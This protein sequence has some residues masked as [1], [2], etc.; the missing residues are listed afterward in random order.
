MFNFP[1]LS[2]WPKFLKLSTL[3]CCIKCKW[4][5]QAAYNWRSNFVPIFIELPDV[6]RN[7]GLRWCWC[8]TPAAAWRGRLCCST[9]IPSKVCASREKTCLEL[10]KLNS[11]VAKV[12]S[13]KCQSKQMYAQKV[14]CCWN[15]NQALVDAVQYIAWIHAKISL[16]LNGGSIFKCATCDAVGNTSRV[17]LMSCSLFF[18][19]CDTLMRPL[20]VWGSRSK[21]VM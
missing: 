16:P 14:L 4:Q 21:A 9:S 2:S 20:V 13:L 1:K 6:H 12:L 7:G 8:A 15:T 3:N 19:V 10:G 11:A 5:K 17:R 18:G